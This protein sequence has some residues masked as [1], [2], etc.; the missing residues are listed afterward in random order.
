MSF[1]GES[2]KF[3]P[4]FT[5]ETVQVGSL[6][7]SQFTPT[8]PTATGLS[9]PRGVGGDTGPLCGMMTGIVGKP[10]KARLNYTVAS[11]PIAVES[12]AMPVIPGTV[13]LGGSVGE[14]NGKGVSGKLTGTALMDFV[15]TLYVGPGFGSCK[16]KMERVSTDAPTLLTEVQE[17]CDFVFSALPLT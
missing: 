11:G 12:Y 13:D 5:I 3:A 4:Q 1:A 9:G 7:Y 16:V 17:I 2:G 10:G 15:G 14:P 8:A 6:V